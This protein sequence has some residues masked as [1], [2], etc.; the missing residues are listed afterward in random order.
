MREC[1]E[2][3]QR[4]ERVQGQ[5]FVIMSGADECTKAGGKVIDPK[6]APKS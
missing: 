6:G 1:A 2:L 3:V 4:P 5:G